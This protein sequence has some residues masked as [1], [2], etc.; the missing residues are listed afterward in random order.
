MRTDSR[1]SERSLLYKG[2]NTAENLNFSLLN[3]SF[4]IILHKNRFLPSAKPHGQQMAFGVREGRR[5]EEIQENHL[6]QVAFGVREG[7]RREEIQENH[8]QQVT[9]GVR[10]GGGRRSKKIIYNKWHLGSG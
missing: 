10:E 6:Q 4:I 1:T 9:F 7:G 3:F 5:R 8:L 2:Y